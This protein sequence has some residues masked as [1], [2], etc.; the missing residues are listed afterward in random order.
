MKYPRKKLKR[1]EVIELWIHRAIL[2]IAVFI[3]LY[4]IVF[5]VANSFASGSTFATSGL[6]SD[7]LT[8]NNYKALFDGSLNDNFNFMKAIKNSIILCSLVSVLQLFITSTS[9]YAFSRLKFKGRKSG[10]MSILI[11]QRFPMI[12]AASAILTVAYKFS[13]TDNIFLLA[14]LLAGTSAF[15][16]WLLKGFMD[17]IPVELDEAAKI[18]GANH[19]QVFVK[20]IIPLAKP[21]FAVILLFSFFGTYSEFVYTKSLLF[22]PNNWTVSVAL[23]SFISDEFAQNWSMF[24]AAAVIA[25]IPQV[26]LFLFLQKYLQSGLT[27]GSVKG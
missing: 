2:W 25:S 13:L 6:F 15:N 12:M 4:P 18:D 24:S 14:I 9:A 3:A 5:V 19:W 10:L 7:K 23:Q 20:I 26:I 11:I 8:L 16:I 21:M 27:A 1:N 22:N 17:N